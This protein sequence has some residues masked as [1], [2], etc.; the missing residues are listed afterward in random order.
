[1]GEARQAIIHAL[2]EAEAQILRRLDAL[3]TM[4]EPHS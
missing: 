3:G 2:R 1:V 4:E